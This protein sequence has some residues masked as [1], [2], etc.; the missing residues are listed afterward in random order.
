[1]LDFFNNLP[2]RARRLY[3]ALKSIK[4][5]HGGTVFIS[6]VFD[7]DKKTILGNYLKCFINNQ[8]LL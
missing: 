7:I 4:L 2:K 1:M 5:G 8:E 6:K 3:A